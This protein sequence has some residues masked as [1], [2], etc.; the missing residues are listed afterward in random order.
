MQQ[1]RREN[2]QLLDTNRDLQ[3][4]ISNLQNKS[5]IEKDDKMGS[6][7]VSLEQRHKLEDRYVH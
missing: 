5:R 3:E 2:R 1:I 7:R 6:R 4:K